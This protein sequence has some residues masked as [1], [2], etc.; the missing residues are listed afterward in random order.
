MD[1]SSNKA[2]SDADKLKLLLQINN[3]ISS[4]LELKP[5]IGEVLKQASR[6]VSADRATLWL[7]DA[8]V[9][10]IYTLVGEGLEE[11]IRL[12]LGTGVAGV[13][14]QKRE[15]LVIDDAYES[16]HFDRRWDL[17][18]GYRTKSLLAV[19]IES[20]DG[21]LLGC[22]QAVNRLDSDCEDGVGCFSEGDV[23]LIGGLASITAVAVENAML[24]EAQKRQF[25]SFIVAMAQTVDAKDSTTS[26]HTRMVTGIAVA[27]AKQ[28]G[29][30]EQQV[31]RV[32]IS[33]ILHDFGK[34]GVPD[35]V[36]LKPGKHDAEERQIMKSHVTKTI[37]ILSRI[38]FRRGLR[39]IPAIAG[40]HHE[41]LDGT[42][43]PFGLKQEEITLEGRILA[44][45]DVFQAL[46]QTRPYKQGFSM[47]K[48]LSILIDEFCAVKDGNAG[49]KGAG[50]HLD[51]NVVTA[52]QDILGEKKDA[53][54]YFE[55]MSGW[56]K[57][58]EL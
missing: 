16:E 1:L 55:R 43:Y 42:G 44:V 58:M 22:F 3:L 33:A 51:I 17:K 48:A 36:L 20:H 8:E 46:T 10:Q 15:T 18:T 34:I 12:P 19:P 54:S 5:L 49:V 14:A 35:K 6:L 52:L 37:L 23:E 30:P 13:A 39:N 50:P 27:L 4:K 9:N 24:Y 47:E 25:N 53:G 31:E 26:N 45:A 28:L 2:V 40:M 38:A 32:R 11:E 56:D 57:M 29:L 7:F 41:K 21:R